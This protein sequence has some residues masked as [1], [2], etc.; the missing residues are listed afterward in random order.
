MKDKDQATATINLK[1]KKYIA[2]L[3][4]QALGYAKPKA[5]KLGWSFEGKKRQ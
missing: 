4:A 5:A 1:H 2:Q 3:K